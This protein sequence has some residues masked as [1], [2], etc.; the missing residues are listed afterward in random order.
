[1]SVL[2]SFRSFRSVHLLSV[3][4]NILRT[5]TLIIAN[6]H[7]HQVPLPCP[8]AYSLRSIPAVGDAC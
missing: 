7:I 5:P 4:P 6:T 3:L 8:R 2:F 1:V